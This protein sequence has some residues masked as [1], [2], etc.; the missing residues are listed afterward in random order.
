MKNLIMI[1][2]VGTTMIFASPS[3]NAQ[4]NTGGENTST[5]VEDPTHAIEY[6]EVTADELP[7][8]I[9]AA[10]EK[11]YAGT[12]ISKAYINDK[13][14]YKLILETQAGSAPQ[15]LYANEKGEWIDP[16]ISE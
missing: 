2:A 14:E 3:V 12:K 16:K 6:K 9:T 13:K 11:D 8:A 15:T 10:L 7:E 5:T 4:E 1:L